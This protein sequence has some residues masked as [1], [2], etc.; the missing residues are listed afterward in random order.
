VWRHKRFG[1]PGDDDGKVGVLFHDWLDAIM[2]E[3]GGPDWAVFEA[4]FIPRGAIS[5]NNATIRRLYGLAM[6][7]Q[8]VAHNWG[9]KCREVDTASVAKHFTGQARWGG[10]EAKKAATRRVCERYGWA[11]VT[12]DEADALAVLVYAEALIDPIAASRRGPGP[13]FVR[14]ASAIRLPTTPQDRRQSR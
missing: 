4:P 9:A 8:M 1:K 10:R 6:I 3:C 11:P 5:V 12:E 2:G 7:A 14:P 13:L